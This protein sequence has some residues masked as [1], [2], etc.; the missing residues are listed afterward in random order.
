MNVYETASVSGFNDIVSGSQGRWAGEQL[1]A[2]LENGGDFSPAILRTNGVLRKEEWIEFDRELIEGAISR[3]QATADLISAGLTKPIANSMGKTV[4][5]YDRFGDLSDAT[6][7]MDGMART[8]NDRPNYTPAQL[9]IPITHKDWRI[10]LRLLAASRNPGGE[11]LDTTMTRL[12]GRK[13]M[14]MQEKTLILGSRQFAGLPIYGY[15]NHPFRQTGGFNTSTNWEAAG[16]TGDGMLIDVQTMLS[17]LAAQKQYGPFWIYVSNTASINLDKD[18][19]ANG[20]DTIR[21][22]LLK[23]ENVAG[24][25]ALDF[26]PNGN[27]LM[28]QALRETV[29]LVQGEPLQ[30]V[31]WD[32]NGGFGVDFKGFMIQVPLVRAISGQSGIF[33]MS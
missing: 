23:V 5:N 25:K 10:H 33:H 30:T 26:L 22:R 28:V 20:S 2:A 29:V 6:V 9:P 31:Q 12:S 7:S 3:T 32:V 24:I 4:L 19:K 13:I 17:A 11:A 16:K 21:Q 8:E 15:T 27:V 14:E 18:F 1:M